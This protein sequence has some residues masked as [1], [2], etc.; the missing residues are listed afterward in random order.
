MTRFWLV[1]LVAEWL[2]GAPVRAEDWPEF[3][4]PTGQG[5][6]SARH[7]PVEWSNTKNVAWKQ[8]IPGQGWSSPVVRAGRIYL[9][10]AVQNEGGSGLSL[11]ALALD[12]VSGR[13]VWNAEV[14]GPDMTKS[15]GIH[16]KNGHAS[17]TP[18]LEGERLYVHFGNQG[19]ACLDLGG[20]ILWRN[21]SLAYPPVH[22][23]GGS[24]VIVEGALVFSCDG[25]SDPFVV[26][27]DKHTGAVLWK[28]SRVTSASKKFSFSTPLVVTVN[29]EKQIISP[30]SG[31]VCAYEPQTGREIWRVRYDEGY[32]V[33]PRPVFGH[34]LVYIATGFDFPKVMAIRPDG[35]G[36]VTA[37]HVA[38]TLKKGAPNTPSLLL[39]GDELY[40]VSDLGI[41]SCVDARTGQVHWQ[42]RAASNCSAS[43]LFAD[44][45]IYV[46]DEEGTGVVLKAG[47]QFQK[48]AI[49]SL[50]ERTLASYA[51]TDNAL[52]IRTAEHLYCIPGQLMPGG[53]P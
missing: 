36:D 12:A 20:K 34:G 43:P 1:I 46:Q 52:L 40:L 16:R 14:F 22:G 51:V 8:V 49:N 17:P 31:A 42:E 15:T 24:P 5:T 26:A 30:G 28:T 18:L 44:G 35:R 4:G 19:T 11:R 50:K 6:S 23:S 2:V 39:G 45:R 37:T 47:K 7:L 9:T 10:T 25:A 48:L 41:V 13:I 3:R 53:Q 21:T 29:R 32:S 27:L 33:I 38:W